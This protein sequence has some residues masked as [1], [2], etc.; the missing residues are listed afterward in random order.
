MD[1]ICFVSSEAANITIIKYSAR[2]YVYIPLYTSF[3][4]TYNWSI[5][6]LYRCLLFDNTDDPRVIPKHYK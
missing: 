1:T 4:T 5:N 6:E 2:L 3:S